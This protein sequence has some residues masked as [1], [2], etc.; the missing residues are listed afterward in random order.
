MWSCLRFKVTHLFD[1]GATV[2][3]AVF[4]AVWGKLTLNFGKMQQ[5][6]TTTMFVQCCAAALSDNLFWCF[7]KDRDY[8][9]KVLSHPHNICILQGTWKLGFLNYIQVGCLLFHSASGLNKRALVCSHSCLICKADQNRWIDFCFNFFFPK[10][11]SV[12]CL[13]DKN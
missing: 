10:W 3:F 2:F 9:A 5:G 13:H 6:N 7:L 4:M 11:L 12:Y 8:C 1:N